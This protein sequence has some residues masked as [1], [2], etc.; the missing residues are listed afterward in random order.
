MGP[1][2]C[3][4]AHACGKAIAPHPGLIR[5][6]SEVRVCP[7]VWTNW[8]PLR[9]LGFFVGLVG[10]Q[11]FL[12]CDVLSYNISISFSCCTSVHELR[13][14]EECLHTYSL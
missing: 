13:L 7:Q 14:Q 12:D 9:D 5:D 2:I 4:Q 10:V 6:D 8:G 1:G 3:L 11:F